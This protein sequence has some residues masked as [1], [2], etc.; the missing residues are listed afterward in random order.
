MTTSDIS[1]RKSGTCTCTLNFAHGAQENIGQ[2]FLS[3]HFRARLTAKCYI[4]HELAVEFE[5]ASD[6]I[7]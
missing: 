4:V 1:R 6:I 5:R 2:N 3:F 7:F